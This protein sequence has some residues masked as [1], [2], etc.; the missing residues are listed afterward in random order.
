[1]IKTIEKRM[2]LQSGAS[3][4]DLQVLADAVSEVSGIG[5]CASGGLRDR[6]GNKIEDRNAPS[7][8]IIESAI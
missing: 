3:L 8:Y 5:R 2:L 4:G 7:S 1:M 6:A